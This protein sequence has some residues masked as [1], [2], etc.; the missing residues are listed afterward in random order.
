MIDPH[1]GVPAWRQL[2]G[3]LRARIESGEWRPGALLP[4]HPRLQHEYAVERATVQRA[5][6]DL[7]QAG[8]VDVERGIGVRVR[9]RVAEERVR[10]ARGSEVRSRMP[11]ATE[12]AEHGLA[13]GV[14]VFV[15]TI[16]GRSRVL[17]GDR[18]VLT[19]A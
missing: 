7:R 9:E 17:P 10:V 5:V 14:P 18:T 4:P 16:G 8:L 3:V 19:F 2:A 6:A 1:S 15:V 13:D 11:T 12:R